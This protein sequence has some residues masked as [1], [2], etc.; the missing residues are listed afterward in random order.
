MWVC[1]CVWVC[2]CR[3]VCECMCISVCLRVCEGIGLTRRPEHRFR[4]LPGEVGPEDASADSCQPTQ[5]EQQSW[6]HSLRS[7]EQ[8]PEKIS[9]WPSLLTLSAISSPSTPHR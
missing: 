2:G 8:P 4:E 5:L 3:W 9:L 6:W 1:E 7:Q